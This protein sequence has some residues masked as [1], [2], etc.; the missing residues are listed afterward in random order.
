MYFLYWLSAVLAPQ[1]LFLN[2]LNINKMTIK[3]PCKIVLLP[4]LFTYSLQK[5]NMISCFHSKFFRTWSKQN[6]EQIHNDNNRCCNIIYREGCNCPKQHSL[7]SSHISVIIFLSCIISAAILMGT[8]K[9]S[10]H[11]FV[12]AWNSLRS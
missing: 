6:N 10:F 4:P 9:H 2:L 5:Q 1:V 3:S 12:I 8:G 7:T 11:D